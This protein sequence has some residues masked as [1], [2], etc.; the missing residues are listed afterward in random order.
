MLACLGLGLSPLSAQISTTWNGQVDNDWFN[1]FNWTAGVPTS[2][3][4]VQLGSVNNGLIVFSGTA[5][6]KDVYLGFNRNATLIVSSGTLTTNRVIFTD[7]TAPGALTLNGGVLATGEIDADSGGIS[8]AVTFNGGTLRATSNKTAWIHGVPAGRLQVL[9]GGATI[10]TQNFSVG[11][12]GLQGAGALTK[13]GTGTLTFSSANTYTGGTTVS[14]GTLALGGSE[15]LADAGALTVN[16]GTFDLG[17]F[18]ETVGAVSLQS[19]SITGTGTLTGSAYD[20]RSGTISAVLGGSGAL[21]KSTS[22]TVALTGSNTYAGGTTVNAGVLQI[23]QDAGLGAAEGTLTLDGGTLRYGSAFNDLRAFTV[24]TAG[25]TLD[26]N[27]FDVS[28]AHDL[29]SNGVLTKSG[30]GTLS[31]TQLTDVP[32]NVLQGTVQSTF[33]S[34]TKSVALAAG[35]TAII[36]DGANHDTSTSFSGAGTLIKTGAGITSMFAASSLSGQIDV[37]EGGLSMG[38]NMLFSGTPDLALAAGT[39]FHLNFR[40]AQFGALSGAG[41]LYNG[42][43]LTLGSAASSTFSGVIDAGTITKVGS[44]TLTLSGS[45]NYTGGTTITAGAIEL[46]SNAGLGGAAG[47][48]TL[49]GGTVRYGAAFNDLRAFTLGSNCG[50][51][52]TNGFDVTYASALAGNNTLTKSGTGTLGFT[53]APDVSLNVLQGTVQ[54]TFANGTKSVAV[55][56]GATANIND[57]VDHDTSTSFS[58]AGTL[59][60]TGTGGTSMFGISTLTG[61]IDVQGGALSMGPGTIFSG[62]PGLSLAAGTAFHLNFHSGQFSTLSGAGTIYNADTLTVGSSVNSAFSG[63]IN[64]G[65]LVKVGSGT[66]TL[67]GDNTHVSA[68]TVSAGTLA[69]GNAGA[70]TGT[71]SLSVGAGAVVAAN[72]AINQAFL[73]QVASGSAGTIA[74]GASSSNALDFSAPGLANVTLGATG[75]FTYSGTLTPANSTYRLGGD[76]GGTLTLGTALSGANALLVA[77]GSVVLDAANAHTGGTTLS[78]G[79]LTVT[80]NG[81]LSGAASALTVNGGTLALNNTLQTVGTLSGSGGTINLGTGHTFTTDTSATSTF[82]GT[83]SGPGA[84]AKAGSGTLTL[85]GNN[86]FTGG[87][88][89]N[90][91][92]LTPGSAGAFGSTGAISFG[93][94]TL[95]YSAANTQDFS[96]RF[97]TAANQAVSVDTGALDIGF[98]TALGSTGGTLTKSGTGTLKLNGLNTYSGSTTLAAGA[99]IVSSGASLSGST[100]NLTI[101]AGTLSL[102]NAAQTVGALSGSGGTISLASGHTLT[103]ST[104]ANTT[105][106]GVLTGDGA[107]TKSGTGTLQFTGVNTY[108]G[109]TTINGGTLS[110]ASGATL[111]A[112]TAPLIV[113]A[114]SLVSFNSNGQTVGTLSGAGG[115]IAL[116]SN[117]TLTT[118]TGSDSTFSGVITGLGDFVKAGTGTLTLGGLNSY[119]GSTTINAG[120]VV[121]SSGGSL[122]A[123]NTPLIVNSGATL[124]FE[125]AAPTAA[126]MQGSGTIVLSEGTTLTST[127]FAATQP[128]TVPKKGEGFTFSGVMEGAGSFTKNGLG[129]ATLSG[130]STYSGAA[131]ITGGRLR[132]TNSTALGSTSGGTTAQGSGSLWLDNVAVG[133]EPVTLSGFGAAD[134]GALIGS[135]TSSLGGPITLAGDSGINVNSGGTL[136]LSGAIDG[137]A[138]LYARGPGTLVLSG[139]NTYTAGISISNSAT[140]TVAST[141]SLA[142]AQLEINTATLNL[143]NAAQTVGT[144]LGSGGTINLAAGHT[145]TTSTSSS[146]N[147]FGIIAGAGAL[148]KDGTGTLNLGGSANT[149]SGGTTVK[150]GLILIDGD[151]ALGAGTVT[152]NGGGLRPGWGFTGLR[153]VTLGVNGGTFDTPAD[154]IYASVLSGAGAFT[155]TGNGIL[156]LNAANTYLGGTPINGGTISVSANANLGAA[157]SAVT[158]GGGTLAATG[159]FTANRATTLNAGGGTFDIAN[160]ITLTWSGNITGAVGNALT[161]IGS[162][163]LQLTGANTFSGATAINAGELKLNGSAAASAFTIN[164]GGTLSGNGTVGALTIGAGGILS[165]G[166]SPGV[167]NAGDTTFESGG[168]FHFEVNDATGARG[169]NYDLLAIT[170]ALDLT[171]ATAANPFNLDLTSLKLADNTAGSAANFDA[172][173]NYS[174]TFLTTTTG[175]TGFAANQFAISTTHF[176]NPFTGSWSVSL[177]NSDHDLTLNYAGVSAIPEPSTYAAALASVAL[178]IAIARRRRHRLHSPSAVPAG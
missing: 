132:I 177:T 102:N 57:A 60:K 123:F 136:T 27:G 86:D 59:L 149:Y 82:G 166:N 79:T 10:D 30:T 159:T 29:S 87:I 64:A 5:T 167:T 73:G 97:S 141:G 137:T 70:I 77:T 66:L 156:T 140:V 89:L 69:F 107:F 170:G 122:N 20:V 45:N 101:N 103:S 25:G 158:F 62:N 14:A 81:S 32:L 52:D 161:K 12:G 112:A 117:H 50:T 155:K 41:T 114:G 175:I 24:G 90:G 76:G 99:L 147:F 2:A 106:A 143:N 163:L 162:G 96:S 72:Y 88:A 113:N 169:T 125:N 152:L 111:S 74:L 80:S 134:I 54:S 171:G 129:L 139:A 40:N 33:A 108:T 4:D 153:D 126:W 144:L 48:L 124:R 26:T 168:T 23:N 56:A 151:S 9:A 34:G 75:A 42:A 150:G 157:T 58:G 13:T 78:G 28:F 85:S 38:L 105:F 95:A 135:G 92:A 18:N 176:T 115:V 131:L 133:A 145:L 16:G 51:L 55:A 91:G 164:A 61:Q 128:P 138:R 3:R 116:A 8:T 110:V 121:V 6:A 1:G 160:G 178:L 65:S 22:G 120:T 7:P 49:D 67:S 119:E 83:L 104:T 47:T 36:N 53:L 142:N 21:T 39:V 174:F 100:A 44:G 130:A 173:A 31:F 43:A 127:V 118:N 15:R 146:S 172:I 37:Q 71:A 68:T 35:T 165:P 154:F 94:G 148:V 11:F 98:N 63:V 84:F 46:T 93:G 19:G 109:G 17:A